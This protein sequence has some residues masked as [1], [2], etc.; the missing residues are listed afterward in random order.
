MLQSSRSTVAVMIHYL[1][2][3]IL[4][5]N[6]CVRYKDSHVVTARASVTVIHP[7][8]GCLISCIELQK[9][10]IILLY[11]EEGCSPGQQSTLIQIHIKSTRLS[12]CIKLFSLVVFLCSVPVIVFIYLCVY[13]SGQCEGQGRLSCSPA[14]FLPA[15]CFGNGPCHPVGRILSLSCPLSFPLHTTYGPA[16]T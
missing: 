11:A 13:F 15:Q 2:V 14:L 10:S 9:Y 7:E 1:Y 3:C 16:G 5:M 12:D 4:Q 6:V 8:L